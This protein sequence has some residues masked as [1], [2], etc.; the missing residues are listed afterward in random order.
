MYCLPLV[1]AGRVYTVLTPLYHV[2]KGKKTWKYFVD[3]D[4]FLRYVRD[5]F[6][7]HYN[8]H[9]TTGRKTDFTKNELLNLITDNKWYLDKMTSVSTNQAIH[10]VLLEDILKI[11]N[12]SYSDIK[13]MVEKKYKYL[14]VS[15]QRDK[16]VVDGTAYDKQHTIVLSDE[17]FQSCQDIIPYIDNSEGKYNVNNKTMGLYE[18]LQLYA[19]SEPKNIDRAKGLGSL[20]DSEIQD[21]ALDPHNRKLLRYTTKDIIKEV[22]EMRKINDDK[23]TLIKDLDISKYEF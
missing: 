13:R 3:K 5:E 12:R 11:R 17:L 23:Y 22:E 20:T 2:D 19:Q 9:H 18:I 14:T 16:I 10:P 15:K 1:E 4:D 21:S 7:K 8:V 6:C